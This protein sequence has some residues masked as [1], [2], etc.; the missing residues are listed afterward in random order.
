[1]ALRCSLLLCL[2]M[3]LPAAAQNSPPLTGMPCL[4]TG[5]VSDYHALPG[6]R[7]L[8]VIDKQRKQYRLDFAAVCESLQP[9]ANLGF[10]TFNPSQYACM[11]RGD[12]VYSSNDVGANRLCRIQAIEYFNEEPPSPPPPEPASKGRAR[13]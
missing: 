7:A 12:S 2:A 10:F 11:A 6:R 4:R 8:V 1:M 3:I 13:G 9:N 5:N